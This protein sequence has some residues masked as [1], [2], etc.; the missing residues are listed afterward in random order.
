[1]YQL[2]LTSY[3]VEYASEGDDVKQLESEASRASSAVSG[4]MVAVLET[5]KGN[6]AHVFGVTKKGAGTK[7]PF[8]V[9][10]LEAV[11]TFIPKTINLF[12]IT[13]V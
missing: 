7:A 3:P 12:C 10:S 13:V 11:S 9:L 4:L 6:I 5:E 2:Q 1:M 8:L